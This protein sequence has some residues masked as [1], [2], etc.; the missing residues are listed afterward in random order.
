M[1]TSSTLD[2][3]ISP[4]PIKRRRISLGDIPDQQKTEENGLAEDEPRLAA[5]E[6]G[7]AT[8]QDHLSYF[9]SHLQHVSRTLDPNFPRLPIEGFVDLYRRN[10][11]PKGRH[12]VIHQHNHPIAGVHY[13]LRLQFSESS[14]ISFALPY[15][16]PGH[17]NSKRPGRMAVETRVH[18]V[19]NH[20]IESASHESGSLLIWDIGEYSVLPRRVAKRKARETD[21]E[22][23]D[24]EPDDGLDP[25]LGEDSRSESEKLFEGF[26]TRFLRLRLHGTRL[27]TNYTIALRL[28]SS[29]DRTPQPR[30]PIRKRRRKDP[31]QAVPQPDPQTTDSDFDDQESNAESLQTNETAMANASDDESEITTIRSTNAYTGATNSI[32]SIHQR[33]WF[34]L[35]DKASSG[36]V[37]ATDG[38]EK[39][40]WVRKGNAG[41][42][43]FFVR[44]AEVE[45][46]AVTGRT[47]T[48]VMADEGVEGFVARKMWRAVLE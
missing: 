20:L 47:S 29:N 44:G 9:S 22:R 3:E 34:L 45:R 2:R 46:S 28:P 24:V 26:Q 30:K 27:P 37:R 21:D 8:V 23:T 38:P 19:W 39:G 15:G 16:V 13:D 4:P 10:Q 40:S 1:P 25:L 35:L 36:F 12:F 14:S 42:E 41:F 48:E 32:G 6:A 43:P 11:H 5:V 18:N 7:Q 31:S 17:P 33:N